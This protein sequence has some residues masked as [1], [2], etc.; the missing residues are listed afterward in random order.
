MM[1]DVRK[2]IFQ[3][4]KAMKVMVG[5]ETMLVRQGKGNEC[6]AMMLLMH[7][8]LGSVLLEKNIE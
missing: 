7:P 4:K 1:M 3:R 8:L 6:G 2:C 5:R